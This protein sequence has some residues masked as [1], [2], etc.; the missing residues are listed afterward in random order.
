MV[1]QG[2]RSVTILAESRN[3]NEF[4]SELGDVSQMSDANEN[5][6][7]SDFYDTDMYTKDIVSEIKLLMR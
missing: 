2:R 1:R 3:C 6:N 5:N 7:V 4:V